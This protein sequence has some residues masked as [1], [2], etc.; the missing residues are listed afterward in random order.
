MSAGFISFFISR[1]VVGLVLLGVLVNRIRHI[2]RPARPVRLPDWKRALLRFPALLALSYTTIH[3]GL[4]CIQLWSGYHVILARDGNWLAEVVA[5]RT[6]VDLPMERRQA[7]ERLLWVS[8]IAA[9]VGLANSNLI[10][11]LEST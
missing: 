6:S 9:C 3:L 2:C 10:R 4:R 5:A 8:Y 7:D 1:Y 11:T